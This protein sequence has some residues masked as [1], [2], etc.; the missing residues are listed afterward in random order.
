MKGNRKLHIGLI[1]SLLFCLLLTACGAARTETVD[2]S[3]ET[4]TETEPETISDSA[5]NVSS[6]TAGAVV[7][8]STE[9]AETASAVRFNPA[10]VPAYSG[11]PVF[12]VN[13]N[14]PYFA[15]SD[16]TTTAFETYSSLDKLGRCGAA[17]ANI[18]REV[19][20]T[21][22]R[23]TIGSV[24]PSGWHTVKYSGVVDGNYLYNRCHLIAYEL[25]GENANTKNLITGTRYMNVQGMRPYEDDTAA[26]V[27]RTGHH[28]LYRVTPI[29][30]GDNLVA[31]GV[32]ME[33]KS[34]EDN[35]FSFCVYAYNVQPGIRIDYATG[36]SALAKVADGQNN[37]ASTP[38]AVNTAP[39]QT[40][41]PSPAAVQDV[42]SGPAV[43]QDVTGTYVVNTNTRKF[44]LPSCTSVG[45]I[46]AKNRKDYTGS[47][48]ALIDQGY[49][50][51]KR[52]NP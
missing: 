50:P 11:D 40:A 28:V 41:T 24:K 38:S 6:A 47:R 36:D 20:P 39:A 49:K 14:T 22:P 19:M 48:Q 15:D 32:L 34:V 18:C 27:E 37:S 51:C 26:Y 45:T 16:L 1:L 13:N 5:V 10:A 31:S 9:E 44:H 2:Q 35:N 21:E 52:C 8:S 17:Y 25:A 23:G 12:V 42:T 29:F 43:T 33:A 3:T 46:K 7:T 30:D 4:E